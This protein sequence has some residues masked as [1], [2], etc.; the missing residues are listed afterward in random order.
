M[1]LNKEGLNAG[2]SDFLSDALLYNALSFGAYAK[3]WVGSTAT[4]DEMASVFGRINYIFTRRY[5]LT[6]TLRADGCS[7]FAK[8][9]QWGY[10]PSVAAAWR[11][12]D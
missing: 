8:G 12:S 4:N 5:L 6:A 2:N 10:F 3:P 7:Y 1:A 11:F 9:H